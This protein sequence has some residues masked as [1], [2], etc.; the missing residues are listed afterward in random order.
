MAE[1]KTGDLEARLTA[2][3]EEIRM[4]KSSVLPLLSEIRARLLQGNEA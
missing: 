1:A 2:L 3:Q 4:L